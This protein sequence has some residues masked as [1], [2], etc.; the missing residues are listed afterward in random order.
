MMGTSH[1]VSGGAAW[2]AMTA[3]TLPSIGAHELPPSTVLLGIGVAAGAA[4]L[5]DADHHNATIAHSIPVAG[6][7]AAGAVGVLSGGHRKGMHSLVAVIAVTAA[8]V[9]LSGLTWNPNWWAGAIHLGAAIAAGACMV[10]AVKVLKVVRSWPLAWAIGIVFG[11][12]IGLMAPEQTNWLPWAIGAGYLTHILGDMLTTG[13]VPLLW[14]LPIRPPKTVRSVP[15]LKRI[16]L[17]QGAFAVPILG[18]TGSW[19]EQALFLALGAYVLWGLCS[20]SIAALR[21]VFF[22]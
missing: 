18:N 9:F 17:P 3:T 12:L 21:G 16:W 6:R 10:F 1:A 22:S 5:P 8:M 11:F 15:V 20:E 14:P 4:L 19:R 13:G 7:L 2:L